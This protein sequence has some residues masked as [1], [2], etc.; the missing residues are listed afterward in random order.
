MLAVV[1]STAL[2]A[3]QGDLES[4][5]AKVTAAVAAVATIV[6]LAGAAHGS[7]GRAGP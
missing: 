1:A 6:H 4:P 7:G 5:G 2:A 3:A